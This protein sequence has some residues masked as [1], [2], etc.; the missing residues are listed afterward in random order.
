MSHFLHAQCAQRGGLPLSHVYE[1]PHEFPIHH[2]HVFMLPTM[3]TAQ[4]FDAGR[5]EEIGASHEAKRRQ[6]A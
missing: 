6:H 5:S 1:L 3:T 2:G 4:T